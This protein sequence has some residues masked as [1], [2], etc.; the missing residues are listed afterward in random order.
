M[1]PTLRVA[2]EAEFLAADLNLLYAYAISIQDVS[3]YPVVLRRDYR[4]TRLNLYFD[5]VLGGDRS[6]SS[7]DIER[8]YEFAGRWAKAAARDPARA[9]LIVHCAAGVSR[10][11]AVAMLPLSLHYGDFRTAARHLFLAGQPLI[12]N[13]HILHLIEEKLRPGERSAIFEAVLEFQT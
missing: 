5:D 13:T 8:I 9:A 10:S 12:P 4:G 6:A 1:Y 7:V 11:A 3:R 2:S